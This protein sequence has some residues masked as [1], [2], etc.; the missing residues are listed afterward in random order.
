VIGI[1]EWTVIGV[2]ECGMD[3]DRNSGMDC[4]RSSV[5][6]CDRSSGMDCDR[7]SGMDCDRSSGMDC[8][9]STSRQ[10]VNRLRDSRSVHFFL[11]CGVW[12]VYSCSPL[13]GSVKSKL[14]TAFVS[15]LLVLIARQLWC[16]M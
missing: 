5:M 10:R 12:L 6:D 13:E 14:G 16:G 1:L 2:P 7:S 9:R 8:D 4:D 3:C 15:E 11:N